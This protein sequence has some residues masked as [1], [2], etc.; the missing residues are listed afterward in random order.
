M[1]YLAT[2]HNLSSADYSAANHKIAPDAPTTISF[3]NIGATKIRSQRQVFQ[4]FNSVL[5]HHADYNGGQK[6]IKIYIVDY[7][8]PGIITDESQPSFVISFLTK[9]LGFYNPENNSYNPLDFKY[10]AIRAQ[11]VNVKA[12]ITYGMDADTRVITRVVYNTDKDINV[13][14][15]YPGSWGYSSFGDMTFKI[16]YPILAIV[17][18]IS[19]AFIIGFILYYD[20]WKKNT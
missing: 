3:A 6:N 5:A 4:L 19:L 14:Y 11:K 20:S 8:E 15:N 17:L 10:L 9:N 2:F 1:A 7:V 13:S 16:G 12:N 18:I